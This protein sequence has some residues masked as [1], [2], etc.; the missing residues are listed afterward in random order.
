LLPTKQKLYNANIL[1]AMYYKNIVFVPSSNYTSE[2]VDPFSIMNGVD[3]GSTSFKIDAVLSNHVELEQI[4]NINHESS[5]DF[6]FESRLNII[7]SII[8][9]NT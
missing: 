1:K 5:L 6:S 9:N 8:E 3:D 2:I 7:K 4:Q